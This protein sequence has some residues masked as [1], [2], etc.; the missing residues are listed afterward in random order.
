MDAETKAKI[1][2]FL[3]KLSPQKSQGRKPAHDAKPWLDGPGGS[4]KDFTREMVALDQMLYV[5]LSNILMG[6]DIY[7]VISPLGIGP[8]ARYTYA[9]I[10][11]YRHHGASASS[12]RIKAMDAVE[13][14]EQ[15]LPHQ[16]CGCG[17]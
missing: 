1:T 11:L 14:L 12:R 8:T 3:D 4:L 16:Q 10:A 5:T 6:T 17:G 9:M 7:H 13:A 2:T 15:A